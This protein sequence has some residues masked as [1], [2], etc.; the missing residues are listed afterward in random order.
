M[1]RRLETQGQDRV[2]NFGDGTLPIIVDYRNAI[3]YYRS[4]HYDR[5][6]G[7][8]WMEFHVHHE[9]VLNFCENPRQ[10]IL[11]ALFKAVEGDEFFPVNYKSGTHVDT[12][13]ARSCQKA[14]DKLFHQ[15]LSL[16]LVTGGT[17]YMTVWLNIAPYKA[18]QISPT[19][20]MSR[21]IDRLMNKLETYNGIPGILNMAN[22]SAQPAFE[23]VVVR[24]NNL[25]TLRLA[26]DI[27]Y[28]N[29]GRRSALKGFSLAN[30]DI[31]DLAPLKLFG[32]VDYAL[33]DLSGNKLASATRLCA[34]L[35][36]FRAKQL[37]MAQN[38][39]TKL[40][41]YPECL[42]PL[43]KNFEEV[44]GVPFDRLYKTYTPLSYEIDMEC[45]GTRI[46]WSNKSALAQF[47]DSSKWHAILIP[48][49]KQEFKK[50]AIIE[51]F[52]INV[53]PELS[54]FY[55]CYYKFTNDEH[56][57]LARKCFDQFEHLVHN[58]NLQI[59]IPS[60]VS[61]DGPIPEYI[62]ER[63][64]SY[65]LKMDV[66]SFKPGQVD[67]KACIV[68]AVQKCYNAVNRVLNL[69]NF[70]QTAGLESVIVKLSSPK[71]VKIVLWIA[72]KRF[73]GSQ[74]VDLRLG[75]N[76]IVS[77]HS[78]RSMAL[79]NGLHALDLSHNWIY[80]LSE[81]S[82][83][84]KVPLKSLRLHGNPLCKNYSLPREY[85]R[86][87]KDMFP[88]LATL[89]G[90]ALNSNPGLAPQKDFLCNTGA[91]ELTGERFLY[92]YLREFEDVD[93]RDNLIRYYS[94]ESYFTLTC[95]YDSSRGM[96]SINLAQR[97]KWYNC[98]RRNLLKSSRYTDNVNVGAH[99]IMEV[100]MTLPKVKHD[101]IS[102]QTDVMHYDDKTAVIY[103]TGLLRDEPDL[104]LA[105]SRQFVL[106][107]D[108]TGLGLGKNARRL[109]IINERLSIMSPTKK[110]ELAAFKFTEPTLDLK[111]KLFDDPKEENSVN[112]QECKL[113][114]FQ[115]LTNLRPRWVTRIVQD[116]ANWNIAEALQLFNQM[117]SKNELPDEAFL[118]QDLTFNKS[119]QLSN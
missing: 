18:G 95:S 38:P 40:A 82:T 62:N 66:S 64:V 68:E 84:S 106:K 96:R 70:Q 78:I 112:V 7:Q 73:M 13:L 67:P 25:A 52:F 16:Q 71:I 45:D 54:E 75:S 76:G 116:E 42:K 4:K 12:F 113:H 60:L 2:I 100:L 65:Y 59:P 34:D 31:S 26:F 43:K 15:R 41:K 101:Y 104:L 87:V 39:I 6:P 58:C 86:A 29:D 3:K 49:P 91:Y 24:L 50:D 98:H 56:R 77:L 20:I 108:K 17:I 89:D 36:R 19:L 32:D 27:I 61:D 81:I 48:D 117:D 74:I 5:A 22:F 105:F 114:V 46:D 119:Q 9:G 88:S 1:T 51:Y 111:P 118:P 90:V 93:K 92:P 94:D 55:P 80:C 44:D 72:S 107:V 14:L 97:L 79:L 33:L 69:E 109:K 28:N 11:N 35:E 102:L 110:Q 30:N 23:N 115:V 103:V 10:L 63:T 85:I 37:L 53:S 83:F 47:K 8:N 21:T 99:E 57:F